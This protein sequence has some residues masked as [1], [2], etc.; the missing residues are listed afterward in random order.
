M[1]TQIKYEITRTASGFISYRNDK[2]IGKY[3]CPTL[4]QAKDAVANGVKAD[5]AAATRLGAYCSRNPS[6]DFDKPNAFIGEVMYCIVL[7]V[8]GL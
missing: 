3:P 8:G 2:Q 7:C 6:L 4:E 5:G 1:A